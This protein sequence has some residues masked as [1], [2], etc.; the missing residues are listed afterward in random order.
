MLSLPIEIPVYYNYWL[1]TIYLLLATT[2]HN[3]SVVNGSAG[4]VGYGFPGYQINVNGLMDQ[5]QGP[6]GGEL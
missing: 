4:A 2:T 5:I 6:Y 1:V 3:S